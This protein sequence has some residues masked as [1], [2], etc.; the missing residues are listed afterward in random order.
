VKRALGALI[1]TG[2]LV[3]A[4][5][6]ATAPA[7]ERFDFVAAPAAVKHA[8]AATAKFVGY[9]VPCPLAVPRGLFAESSGG[10]CAAGIVFAPFRSVATCQGARTWRGRV[11]GA[12]A[13]PGGVHFALTAAPRVEP[14]IARLV[15]GPAWYPAARVR[16]LGRSRVGRRL[17]RWASVPA[18]TNDGSQ[19]SGAIVAAWSA[20]G[21]SYAIGFRAPGGPATQRALGERLLKDLAL[22]GPGP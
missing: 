19:F 20:D 5:P 13:T 9:P 16:L 12:G 10:G 14:G 4:L 17:V 18:A 15:N 22:V 3:L 21:H 7:R 2:C 11:A 8:C 1:C 6:I